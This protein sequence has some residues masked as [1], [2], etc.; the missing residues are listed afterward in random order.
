MSF[1]VPPVAA[2]TMIR[3]VTSGSRQWLFVDASNRSA[4]PRG[5]CESS[6]ANRSKRKQFCRS[7]TLPDVD[8]LGDDLTQAV[9][10]DMTKS[11]PMK[12]AGKGKGKSR[13][14]ARLPTKEMIEEIDHRTQEVQEL[15]Q[16]GQAAIS[17]VT[18]RVTKE[19][20]CFSTELYSESDCEDTDESLSTSWNSLSITADKLILGLNERLSA[21]AEDNNFLNFD[22]SV[23]P[24]ADGVDCNEFNS[25]ICSSSRS[26]STSSPCSSPA[27]SAVSEEV[28][29][30]S[31]FAE[32]ARHQMIVNQ[33]LLEQVQAMQKRISELQEELCTTQDE[34]DGMYHRNQYLQ[35]QLLK[36]LG[37]SKGGWIL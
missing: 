35:A 20:D 3:T 22:L 30:A 28:Q 34:R 19:T 24:M 23:E 29:A 2:G 32:L 1:T 21:I 4:K 5:D 31:S 26:A 17:S 14:L 33:T 16:L 37:C 27:A 9:K 10:T 7:V 8:S 6:P 12:D 15:L 25:T 18:C 36:V 11:Q 13:V